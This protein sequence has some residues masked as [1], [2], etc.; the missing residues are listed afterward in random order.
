PEIRTFKSI[1]ESWLH[2]CKAHRRLADLPMPFKF[3]KQFAE[4]KL[5]APEHRQGKVTFDQYLAE[6]YPLS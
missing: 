5:L 2:A 6:R 4:G 1:A 3:S